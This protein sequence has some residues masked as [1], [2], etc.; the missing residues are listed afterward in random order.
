MLGAAY[1]TNLAGYSILGVEGW[2]FAFRTVAAV[3]ILIGYMTLR[4]A[5]DPDYTAPDGSKKAKEH[6][7][8]A[9]LRIAL[10]EFWQVPQLSLHR[11]RACS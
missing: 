10:Q 9:G 5:R 2:R 1:A 4:L 3:A 7:H 11:S 8:G 6:K